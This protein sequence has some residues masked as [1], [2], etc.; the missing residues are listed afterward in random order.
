MARDNKKF[1]ATRIIELAEKILKQHPEGGMRYTDLCEEIRQLDPKLNPHTVRRVV[2]SAP[3]NTS[4]SIAK[5]STM[6][7]YV[8]AQF[9][10]DS[11]PSDIARGNRSS[12]REHAF[13][14]SLAEWMERDIE[15]VTKAVALGGSQ[16]PGKW[17]TPDV[18]GKKE[19]KGD[20]FPVQ[21]ELISAEI[22]IDPGQ[23][24]IAFGQA[25]AYC[26]FSHRSYVVVPK[27]VDGGGR[28]AVQEQEEMDRLKSLCQV[29]G[30]GLV[31]F[32]A[33]SVEKPEYS[34]ILRARRQ[35]PNYRYLN[36]VAKQIKDK[37]FK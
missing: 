8:H 15:E 6:G 7:R 37:L 13:Y 16:F 34:L 18:I 21:M 5:H 12:G 36:E 9:L 2:W 1:V 26:L 14:L 28:R 32:N 33:N 11:S 4:N 3:A 30:I 24:V 29:F 17:G 19:S 35:E 31:S 23:L 20:I 27:P 25:C 22:K 10:G